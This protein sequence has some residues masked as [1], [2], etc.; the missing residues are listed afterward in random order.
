MDITDICMLNRNPGA[1]RL[2]KHEKVICRQKQL[3]FKLLK[4]SKILS[5]TR[6]ALLWVDAG[7]FD[8][9]VATS[10]HVTNHGLTQAVGRIAISGL[11][12]VNVVI[13]GITLIVVLI[14]SRAADMR[15]VRS[16]RVNAGGI[17]G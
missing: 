1:E 2:K 15:I 4:T 17:C 13:V 3:A 9:S 16:F 10:L 7:V 12:V 6:I 14:R 11:L 5:D 8:A